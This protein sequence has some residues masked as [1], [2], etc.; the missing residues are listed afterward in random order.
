MGPRKTRLLKERTAKYSQLQWYFQPF[1]AILRGNM[2]HIL[3]RLLNVVAGLAL[4]TGIGL[5]SQGMA[6]YASLS[7]QGATI[8]SP[9]K[10]STNGAELHAAA[11]SVSVSFERADAGLQLVLGILLIVLG[12]FIHG[13]VRARQEERP[14]HISVVP[15]RKKRSVWYW[16]EMRV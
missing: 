15:S 1:F 4:I 11:D 16:L 10:P 2:T 14:V 8:L 6:L 5:S 9:A 7:G 13:L 12:F 3:H